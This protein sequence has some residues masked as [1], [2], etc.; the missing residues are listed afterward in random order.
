MID[1][2]PQD[3]APWAAKILTLKDAVPF[4]AFSIVMINGNVHPVTR[5]EYVEVTAD[6]ACAELKGPEDFWAVLALD[7]VEE[8]EVGGEVGAPPRPPRY[9]AKLRAL[10]EGGPHGPLV[11][12]MQDGR[13]FA[14]AGPHQFLLAPDGRSVAV[15][16]QEGGLVLLATSEISDLAPGT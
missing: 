12:T 9:A 3:P 7:W 10:Q 16:E 5:P 1:P 14:P 6:G 4:R 13:R 8:I 2:S 15:C 11:L